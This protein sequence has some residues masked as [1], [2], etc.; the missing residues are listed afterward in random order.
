VHLPACTMSWRLCRTSSKQGSPA[1]IRLPCGV[2]VWPVLDC[3]AHIQVGFRHAE[4]KGRQLLHNGQPV[5]IKG[6]P[7]RFA[8]A[9]ACGWLPTLLASRCGALQPCPVMA[10]CRGEPT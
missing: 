7:A 2:S 4:V 6:A 3:T 8:F 10:C 5:M 1:C 9:D